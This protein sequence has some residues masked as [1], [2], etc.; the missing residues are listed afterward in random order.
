[1]PRTSNSSP[2]SRT[3]GC[4]AVL[5]AAAVTIAGIAATSPTVNA[6]T[7][8]P[9]T[10]P[11]ATQPAL[12]LQ[13]TLTRPKDKIESTADGNTVVIQVTS[14]SGIGGAELAPAAGRWPERIVLR[15]MHFRLLE[16]VNAANG[17][18]FCQS[19][20]GLHETEVRQIKADGAG[21]GG[22][23][24]RP[25]D[26]AI[27]VEKHEGY[28][29]VVLPAALWRQDTKSIRVQWVDAYR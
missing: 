11:A 27:A 18:V 13:I 26:Y 9:T 20:L 24:D 4:L 14:A 1:M 6:P 21:A 8:A 17:R 5:A 7:T 2:I 25:G 28:I 12:N 15:L 10:G 16:G 23:V 19:A 22:D 3:A 29:E